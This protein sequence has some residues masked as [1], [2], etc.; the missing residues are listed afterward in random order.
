MGMG[1]ILSIRMNATSGIVGWMLDTDGDSRADIDDF[2]AHVDY[3][4]KLVGIDHVGV[5]SDAVVNGWGLEEIHYADDVLARPDR[6]KTVA[7]RLR[8]DYGYTDLQLKK[9]LGLNFKR[10]YEAGLPPS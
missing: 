4:V 1:I 8:D 5:A 6:W 3:M 10:R 9:V 2:L 7:R